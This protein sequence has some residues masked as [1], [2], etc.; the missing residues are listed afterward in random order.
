MKHAPILPPQDDS[1]EELSRFLMS[2]PPP[3][4]IPTTDQEAEAAEARAMEDVAAGRVYSH[5]V[6]SEWLHTWGKPEF[7]PFKEWIAGRDA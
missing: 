2:M 7:K 1:D 4:G 5:S 6:I 3:P